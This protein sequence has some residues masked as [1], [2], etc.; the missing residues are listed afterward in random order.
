MRGSQS[1]AKQAAEGV[2]YWER[3]SGIPQDA[4][5]EINDRSSLRDWNSHR[6]ILNMVLSQN[7]EFIQTNDLNAS[8]VAEMAS[9]RNPWAPQEGHRGK[10]V[11]REW[12]HYRERR[13]KGSDP[14]DLSNLR[15]VTPDAHVRKL[16]HKFNTSSFLTHLNLVKKPRWMP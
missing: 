11:K 4:H 6:R 8:D 16:G 3:R 12:D 13:E 14:F 1:T 9:G 5:T 10:R 15:L 2:T 7:E